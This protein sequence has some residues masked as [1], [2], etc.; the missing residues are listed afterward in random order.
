MQKNH[1]LVHGWC[2]AGSTDRPVYCGVPAVDAVKLLRKQLAASITRSPRTLGIQPIPM[3]A[4]SRMRHCYRQAMMLR[5]PRHQYVLL[6][7]SA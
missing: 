4:S 5:R 2:Q 7:K 6:C 3:L 1:S